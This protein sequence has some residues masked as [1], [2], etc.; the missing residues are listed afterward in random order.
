MYY[1]RINGRI[2]FIKTGNGK[3]CKILYRKADVIE[4]FSVQNA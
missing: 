1:H 4:F 2:P 3:N